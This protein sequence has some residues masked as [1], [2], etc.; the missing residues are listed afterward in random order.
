ML[1][2]VVALRLWASEWAHSAVKFFYDNWAVVQVVKTGKTRDAFLG[3]G[4][5]IIWLLMATY[6]IDLQIEHIV[7]KKN[8]YA[9]ALS[10]FYSSKHINSDLLQYFR[11]NFH[12]NE[13]P[14]LFLSLDL[15]V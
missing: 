13:I 3:D 4:S 5:R 2:L 7:G 8:I 14:D 1:N 12:W 6:D 11:D 10:Q 9:Y 15:H